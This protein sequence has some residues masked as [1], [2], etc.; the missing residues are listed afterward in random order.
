MDKLAIVGANG[1]IG[2]RAVE[3]F[4]LGDL[5]EVR[6]IVRSYGSLVRVARFDL[7][8]RIADATDREALKN[9]FKDAR[10]V[11]HAALGDARAMI[12][13]V[14]AVYSAA[15]EAGVE[16]IVYLS[17]IAVHGAVPNVGASEADV[18]GNKQRFVYAKAKVAAEKKLLQRR[19]RGC[20][21]VVILRPGIVYG[22]RSWLWTAG[23]ANNL[24]AGNA[25]LANN[26]NGICNAVYVDNL[27][28]M[29]RLSLIL[30]KSDKQV[31]LAVDDETITWLEYY[32]CIARA[33]NINPMSIYRLGE[34]ETKKNM[35]PTGK[36]VFDHMRALPIVQRILPLLSG[37]LKTTI[38]KLV[39]GKGSKLTIANSTVD[40]KLVPSTEMVALQC[41]SY[42]FPHKKAEEVLGYKSLVSFS[43]GMGRAIAWLKFAGYPVG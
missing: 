11:F 25:Y 14:D 40:C 23:I 7:D 35:H 34:A 5:F 2:S 9:A 24:L 41:C 21:E 18:I 4:H 29:A 33:L 12:D 22:P 26:G 13:S 32:E 27:L 1:F 37:E 30:N 43:E 6:P 20:V 19:E 10:F 38:K 17:S 42:K 16:R 39:F 31:F 3:F 36:E 15:E 28:E 8:C